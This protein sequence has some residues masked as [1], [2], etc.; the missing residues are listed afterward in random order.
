MCITASAS[1]LNDRHDLRSVG[2]QP[3]GVFEQQSTA[4]GARVPHADG[5][6]AECSKGRS[7]VKLMSADPSAPNLA[8]ARGT[9]VSCERRVAKVTVEASG[10]I[11]DSLAHA[12]LAAAAATTAKRS[13]GVRI[14]A[15]AFAFW[16]VFPDVFAFGP[17]I[18][19]ALWLRFTQGPAG[20]AAHGGHLHLGFPLYAMAHSVVVFAAVYGVCCLVARRPIV[21][22]TGWLLHILID[23]PT[24]SYSYYATRFLWPLS[25]FAFNG[26]PW[27]RAW[28]WWSTY[29]CL[30]V[31]YVIL[32]RKGWLRR[33][34]AHSDVITLE[35]TQ[36]PP[37]SRSAPS[38]PRV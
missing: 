20:L 18:A 8:C 6:V 21:S 2:R 17:L 24:H 36:S 26:V 4:S 33:T 27:W 10:T 38:R 9:V 37:D 19:A 31:A 23:I 11:V 28:L 15:L 34:T 3:V 7:P 12:L 16:A 32:W 30:S 1:G 35:R 29:A 22:M 5:S 13:C 14:R 25:D